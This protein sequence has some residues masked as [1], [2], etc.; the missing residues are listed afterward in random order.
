MLDIIPTRRVSIELQMRPCLAGVVA[1]ESTV[2]IRGVL[3]RTEHFWVRCILKDDI[4]RGAD[5]HM[6]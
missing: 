5:S 1:F 3:Q 4:C 6:G 2:A